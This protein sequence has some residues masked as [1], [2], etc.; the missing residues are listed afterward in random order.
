MTVHEDGALGVATPLGTVTVIDADPTRP[1][2]LT[3]VTVQG[4][5]LVLTASFDVADLFG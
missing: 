2:Q 1:F 3:S 4:G 5:S